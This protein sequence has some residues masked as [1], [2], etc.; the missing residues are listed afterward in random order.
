M[1]KPATEGACACLAWLGANSLLL[2]SGGFT[3]L[4]D[5]YFSRLGLG[6]LLKFLIVPALPSGET[7]RGALDA[8]GI[9][10]ADAVLLSHAHFNHAFDAL[11]VAELASAGT[12]CAPPPLSGHLGRLAPGLNVVDLGQTTSLCLGDFHV[13]VFKGRHMPFPF[14][15]DRIESLAAKLIRPRT[16]RFAWQYLAAGL[17]SFLI[18]FQGRRLFVMGSAGLPDFR[19]PCP[20]IDTLILSV[21]GLDL[22][23]AS[24]CGRLMS[25][26]RDNLNPGLILLSH[27]DDFT[28]PL[29]EPVRWL[30]KANRAVDR[31]IALGAK[32]RLGVRLLPP[33]ET[34]DPF[35]N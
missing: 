9:G 20:S 5:P 15:L 32:Y 3:L 10:S 13:G 19:L 29:N 35:P 21:G 7:I 30:G 14:R 17:Y 23:P 26:I 2:R 16:Y 6:D 28:R 24:Y 1:A 22:L 11:K 18:S 4:I 27:W 33:G 25:L 34:V 31:L 12:L 8:T